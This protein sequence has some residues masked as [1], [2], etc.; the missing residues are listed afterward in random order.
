MTTANNT[1]SDLHQWRAQLDAVDRQLLELVAER[2]R[3]VAHIGRSKHR[4]GR[5]LRDFQR[6]RQV[7]EQAAA[8]G[9]EL[10]LPATLCQHLMSLLIEHSLSS[11]E[12]GSLSHHRAGAGRRALVIGGLGRMGGW[13]ADF[14]DIQGYNVHIAD[15]AATGTAACPYP[16]SHDWRE[17][18]AEADLIAIAAPMAAS[19]E[20]LSELGQHHQ[21]GT[22]RDDVLIF[23]VG[24][25]KTPLLPAL[26]QLAGRGLGVVS[27]HPLFG[28]ATHMLSGRHVVVVDLG[29]PTAAAQARALFTTTMAEVVTLDADEHDRLMAYVLSFS[30]LLNIAFARVLARGGEQALRLRRIS[31]TSFEEQLK[32]ARR[33]AAENPQVYYEI[34]ALNPHAAALRQEQ[35]H[36]LH[37]ITNAVENPDPTPFATLMTHIDD[38]VESVRRRH[39]ETCIELLREGNI[40][41]VVDGEPI[42][43]LVHAPADQGV[44]S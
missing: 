39:L 6:E 35:Q 28:P 10:G 34:Q 40:W 13:F 19:A 8:R 9:A 30:H 33:I 27:L 32:V 11:Q 23:D 29:H 4:Q 5:H 14:L 17:A 36:A 21:Q 41:R 15:H 20:I 43:T 1:D 38:L 25:L 31:S 12:R 16:L 26:K 7:L 37:D 22:L 3:I 24:S 44:T 42:G 18:I 2:Q